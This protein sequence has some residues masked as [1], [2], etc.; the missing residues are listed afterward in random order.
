[1]K[2]DTTHQPAKRPLRF[3]TTADMWSLAEAL[4]PEWAAAAVRAAAMGLGVARALR[5]VLAPVSDRR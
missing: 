4:R 2:N 5:R 3:R 1:M